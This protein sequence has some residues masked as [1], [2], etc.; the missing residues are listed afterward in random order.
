MTC[1]GATKQTRTTV[2][3]ELMVAA[4]ESNREDRTQGAPINLWLQGPKTRAPRTNAKTASK[5]DKQGDKTIQ[6]EQTAK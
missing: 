1:Q 3:D 4:K 5:V 6:M 2:P